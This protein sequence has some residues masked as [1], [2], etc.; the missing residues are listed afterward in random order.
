MLFLLAKV[1]LGVKTHM[2]DIFSMLV[3][4]VFYLIIIELQMQGTKSSLVWIEL[5]LN[6]CHVLK[7]SK[8]N[9]WPVWL[10]CS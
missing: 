6:I 5:S 3:L 8:L 9:Y 2:C 7:E 10:W 4:L 1:A